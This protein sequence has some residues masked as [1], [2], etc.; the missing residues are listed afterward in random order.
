MKKKLMELYKQLIS[1]GNLVEARE[2]LR[3][4]MKKSIR[5]GL[6]DMDWDLNQRLLLL[7]LKEHA[8]RNGNWAEFYFR[9]VD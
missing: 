5:L 4:L 9:E 3:F 2:V 7:G 6:S 1:E 8:S